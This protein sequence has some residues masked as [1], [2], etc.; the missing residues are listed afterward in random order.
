[1]AM[2]WI[3]RVK[4][5]G[6]LLVY[7][8]S[9]LATGNWRSIFNQA[10]TQFNT[11]SSRNHL[12]VTLEQSSEPPATSGDGGADVA[13]RAANGQISCTYDGRR[14]SMAFNGLQKQGYTHSFHINNRIQKTYVFLPANPQV[15]TSRGGR[16]VGPGVKL[17]IAVHEFVHACGLSN[18]DHC[19]NDL[20]HPHPDVDANLEN[21]ALDKV[22]I[23]YDLLMPPLALSATTAGLVRGL[24]TV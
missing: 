9:S 12:R 11:L 16:T 3:N 7:P 2:P 15:H 24:W 18:D 23:R 13:V 5:R 17:L 4:Q 6:T 20:M 19:P 21:P 10:I 22:R 8:D 1:M 14:D